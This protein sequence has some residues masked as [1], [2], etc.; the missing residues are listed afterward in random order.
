MMVEAIGRDPS[1]SSP[2]QESPPKRRRRETPSSF[3]RDERNL[4][5]SL[6]AALRRGG[7]LSQGKQ[8]EDKEMGFLKWVFSDLGLERERE[9]ER[10]V[11][12]KLRS[13]KTRG[14]DK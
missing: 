11:R 8:E 13:E 12:E 3:V 5:I 14:T 6:E 7:G 10:V 4:S 1:I 2:T 9:R